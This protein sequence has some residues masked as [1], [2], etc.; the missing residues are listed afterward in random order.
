MVHE[1]FHVIS[2]SKEGRICWSI[3]VTTETNSKVLKIISSL[4]SDVH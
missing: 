2:E 3:N 4:D 1:I